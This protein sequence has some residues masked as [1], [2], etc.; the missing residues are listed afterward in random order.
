VKR[1]VSVLTMLL[2]TL[3]SF[4]QKNQT[5][6]IEITIMVPENINAYIDSVG[7]YFN[8]GNGSFKS[9][10]FIKKQIR[11]PY[12]TKKMR[13]SAE[14]AA[15]VIPPSGGPAKARVVYFKLKNKIAYVLLDIDVD[16]WAGV[17][18][19]IFKIHPLIE[20]TLLQFSQIHKVIFEEAPGE[21]MFKR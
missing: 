16:G 10:P 19:S 17:S 1:I 20:Q 21:N 11:I 3:I 18:N 5:D 14:V 2:I 12:T 13:A 15:G 9:W 7:K 6:S 8:N 4:A